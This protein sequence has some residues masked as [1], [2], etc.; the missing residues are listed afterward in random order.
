MPYAG[1]RQD[2]TF[3]RRERPW[4]FSGGAL[5]SLTAGYVN[6]ALLTFFHVPVSH[7]TGAVSRLSIDVEAANLV[8]LRL[9]LSIVSAFF[10]GSVLSG[11]IIGAR[12]LLPERR[13]GVA[14]LCEGMLLAFAGLLLQLGHREGVVLAAMACGVQNAMASSYHGLTLRTTHVTGI[15]TDLGVMLGHWLRHR[16]VRGWKLMILATI[17][18]CFFV[19]GI[20]GA[21]AVGRFGAS[22]LL[23]PAAECLVLGVTY[24]WWRHRFLRPRVDSAPD[25]SVSS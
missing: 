21:L 24:V 12:A 10:L 22:A 18:T 3:L 8:D 5:L 6:V 11:A 25:G 9:V 13:Y 16:T 17:L 20:L 7:M 14:L 23:I 19:G 1:L 4:V 15:V 2:P